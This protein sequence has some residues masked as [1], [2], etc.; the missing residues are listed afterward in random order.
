MELFELVDRLHRI[1][2]I[3]TGDFELKDGTNSKFYIDVRT[4][5]QHKTDFLHVISYMLP[6]VSGL[7]VD[8]LIGVPYA[9][10]PL[11][12]GL[13]L[14]GNKNM[15]LMRTEKKQYGTKKLIEGDW[16]PGE[17]VCLIDDIVTTGASKK[18][19]IDIIRSQGLEVTDIVTLFDRRP[20]DY[21]EIDGISLKSFIYLEYI[22]KILNI[23]I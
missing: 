18:E 8:Y 20:L 9:G 22:I 6:F 21:Y 14:L 23:D 3:K 15:L 13:T 12:T 19:C 4:L 5:Y 7:N 1:N 16:N 2:V 11:A 10:I 17:K